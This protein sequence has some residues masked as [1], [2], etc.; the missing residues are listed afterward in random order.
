M[1]ASLALGP[2]CSTSLDLPSQNLPSLH[3][4]P[5]HC[6]RTGAGGKWGSGTHL[7]GF[8]VSPFLVCSFSFN[9]GQEFLN[10]WT[11]EFFLIILPVLSGTG[12]P[13]T[14]GALVMRGAD[15]VKKGEKDRTRPAC[16]SYP[17]SLQGWLMAEQRGALC[18]PNQFSKY[19]ALLGPHRK[20][21]SLEKT[22]W[23]CLSLSSCGGKEGDWDRGLPWKGL[24][25]PCPLK[26]GPVSSSPL[27]SGLDFQ[28]SRIC[29]RWIV[30]VWTLR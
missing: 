30:L 18:F 7:S 27:S 17:Q 14:P 9:K 13:R 15:P 5:L 25:V 8:L 21:P 11:L 6:R 29:Y 19:G 4:Q 26:E 1:S 20:A 10:F 23:S 16:H 3:F 12:I 2:N 22:M 24:Q 28:H